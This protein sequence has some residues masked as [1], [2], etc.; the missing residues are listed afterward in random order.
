MR[1]RVDLWKVIGNTILAIEVDENQHK[2][3][4]KEDEE[5]RYDD[6]Y[7]AFSGK[8]IFIRFNPNHYR[9]TKNKIVKTK[10]KDRIPTLLQEIEKYE[11][12]GLHRVLTFGEER[13][14][15]EQNLDLVEIHRLFYDEFKKL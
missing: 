12:L 6:L 13:I 8:W 4:D 1:R 7:M 10:V 3:Y 2:S 9:D 15:K 14:L 5:I 11:K